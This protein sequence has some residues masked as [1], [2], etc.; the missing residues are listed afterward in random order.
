MKYGQIAGNASINAAIYRCF[1]CISIDDARRFVKKFRE[2][3]HDQDQVMHTFRELILGAFL[4]SKG[5][6]I[7][8]DYTIGTKTPDWCILDKKSVPRCIV[9][10]MNFHI[11]KATEDDIKAQRQAKR[12]WVG[13][14]G[15]NYDRLYNC[16][17]DKACIYRALVDKYQVP[18]VI[19]VFGEFT[20]NVDP[21]ELQK[22]L[23]DEKSG[24]FELYP[25]VSGVLYFEENIGQYSFTYTR[26]PNSIR[27][28]ELPSGVF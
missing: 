9:E 18:Y 27:E 25:A 15:S 19:A 11:D 7:K 28:M 1:E 6:K 10:L 20:T 22:C 26:N 4:G 14:P 2:Q 17:W 21:E 8:Y 13:W 24:L 3:P 5:F 16:L 12:I 23:F